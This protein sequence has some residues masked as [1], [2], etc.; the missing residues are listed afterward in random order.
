MIDELLRE[1]GLTLP[2]LDGIAFG[3]GPG[4]FTGLRIAAGV[5][6][7]LAYRRRS[8]GGRVSSLAAVAGRVPAA[9]GAS[10]SR[11]QRRTHGRALLG[12]FPSRCRRPTVVRR[13]GAGRARRT[14]STRQPLRR[15]MSPGNG[16]QRTAAAQGRA[17][18]A[19]AA[20]CTRACIRGPTP[21]PGW[22]LAAFAAGRG[23]CRPR[24]R[25]RSMFVTKL[26]SPHA[27]C[28]ATVIIDACNAP[29]TL[30]ATDAG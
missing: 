11:L 23:R 12:A 1:A 16:L 29:A 2:E 21:S 25:C 3:R 7:G 24:R 8:Q 4:A 17:E 15:P 5:T 6:Q 14:G 26:H 30:P 9:A 20:Y 19:R 28:H 10:H 13:A 18:G 22:R 27:P